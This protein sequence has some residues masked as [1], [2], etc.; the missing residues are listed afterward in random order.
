[1]RL[2]TRELK[3]STAFGYL[4]WD[5]IESST[6]NPL[7]EDAAQEPAVQQVHVA[8]NRA[9]APVLGSPVTEM[10]FAVTKPEQDLITFGEIINVLLRSAE[11][12]PG[13]IASSWGYTRENPNL[14]VIMVGWE[15]VDVG[16]SV[17]I[18]ASCTTMVVNF[19]FRL[20]RNFHAPKNTRL[21]P[22]RLVRVSQS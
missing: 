18:P 21:Y 22:C 11:E 3:L 4:E 20:T 10:I 17:S 8:F 12:Q 6:A 13:T 7:I 14:A 9:L 16:H 2:G 15:S 19:V 1:M 5:S